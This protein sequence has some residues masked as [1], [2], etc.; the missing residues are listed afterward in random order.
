MTRAFRRPRLRLPSPQPLCFSHLPSS[1]GQ[2]PSLSMADN[3]TSYQK[4]FLPLPASSSSLTRPSCKFTMALSAS[5]SAMPKL[6]SIC[7]KVLMGCLTNGTRIT[8]PRLR[9]RRR[10]N[11]NRNMRSIVITIP[12]KN[13][14]VVVRRLTIYLGLQVGNDHSCYLVD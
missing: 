11:K 12:M 9:N 3:Q 2:L 4:E 7:L 1:F 10:K 5:F 13:L 6:A 14:R 8:H